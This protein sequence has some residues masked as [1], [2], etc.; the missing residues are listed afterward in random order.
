MRKLLFMGRR[1]GNVQAMTEALTEGGF[2]VWKSHPFVK[3]E[4]QIH[5]GSNDRESTEKAERC[6]REQI[7]QLK[8]INKTKSYMRRNKLVPDWL[9]NL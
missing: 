9:R 1:E 3:T 8:S 6:Y 5:Q 4:G 2:L 7:F